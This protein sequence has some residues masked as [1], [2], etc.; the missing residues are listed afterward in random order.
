MAKERRDKRAIIVLIRS[1]C[2]ISGS[3]S[4][5]DIERGCNTLARA[6]AK[7]TVSAQQDEPAL[8]KFHNAVHTHRKSV[9]AARQSSAATR[10]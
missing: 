2:G 5:E 9:N 7:F 1:T 6:F 4:D 10:S 3:V 8:V